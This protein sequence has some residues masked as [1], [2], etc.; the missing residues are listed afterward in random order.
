MASSAPGDVRSRSRSVSLH[1]N[2]MGTPMGDALLVVVAIIGGSLI[3]G[4]WG[5]VFAIP[6]VVVVKTA[7]PLF[8]RWPAESGPCVTCRTRSR[9]SFLCSGT[10]PR[11]QCCQMHE[12]GLEHRDRKY[13]AIATELGAG[14][15]KRINPAPPSR[16]TEK[17]WLLVLPGAGRRVSSARLIGGRP[18]EKRP[19]G[20]GG[21]SLRGRLALSAERNADGHRL[22][23]LARALVRVA[24]FVIALRK[25]LALV[26][27]DAARSPAAYR[28]RF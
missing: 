24:L 15:E 25:R 2:E 19:P 28:Q 26:D 13:R 27:G 5:M 21:L 14:D 7:E 20:E 22:Q 16:S 6:T 18:G 1:R 8:R 11:L 10:S 3:M 12:L 9:F 4:L 23:C 17:S